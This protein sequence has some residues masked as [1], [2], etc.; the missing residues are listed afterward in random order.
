MTYFFR[1]EKFKKYKFIIKNIILVAVSLFLCLNICSCSVIPDIKD[2]FR[3][4]IFVDDD[5][6]RAIGTVEIFFD[7]LIARD[8]VRAYEYLSDEDKAMGNAEDFSDEFKD[9]TDIVSID[10]NRVE[11]KNNIAIV[12]IDITDSYDGEEKVFDNIDVSL[13]RK[14]D[15]DWKIVFWD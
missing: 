7:L 15:G 1:V 3:D 14:E 2:Y 8:Y 12:N 9:V 13:I 6:D 4:K 10:I 11:V 5:M